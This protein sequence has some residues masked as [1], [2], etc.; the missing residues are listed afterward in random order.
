[1]RKLS[2]QFNLDLA[3]P[4]QIIQIQ[5]KRNIK[6]KTVGCLLKDTKEVK[7]A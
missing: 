7:N 3:L 4:V 2:Y 5:G 1:M 6:E